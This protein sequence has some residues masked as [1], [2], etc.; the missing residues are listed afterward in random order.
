MY[1]NNN[2][3]ILYTSETKTVAAKSSVDGLARAKIVKE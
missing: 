1:E 2:R 3:G